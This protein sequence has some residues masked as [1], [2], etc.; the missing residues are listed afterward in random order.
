MKRGEEVKGVWEDWGGL[1][2][3]T[4]KRF[5]KSGLL[6]LK[7]GI[8]NCYCNKSNDKCDSVSKHHQLTSR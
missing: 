6:S 8:S 2:V 4:V 5:L 3:M 7:Q 1:R